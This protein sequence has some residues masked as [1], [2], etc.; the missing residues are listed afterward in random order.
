M[1]SHLIYDEAESCLPAELFFNIR[2]LMMYRSGHQREISGHSI[3]V[4]NHEE[5]YQNKGVSEKIHRK[6]KWIGNFM[7]S[8][9]ICQ[10]ILQNQ[11]QCYAHNASI[12]P[13]WLVWGR[14]AWHN[15]VLIGLVNE[16]RP[17]VKGNPEK[18]DSP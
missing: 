2:I 8:W 14:A 5:Q 7:L 9:H 17:G 4:R 12:S 16:N 1:F 18:K 11:L 6:I 13:C 3:V 10:I 15:E